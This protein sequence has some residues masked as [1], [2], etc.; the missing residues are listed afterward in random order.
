MPIVM[1]SH[2]NLLVINLE[3]ELG[4]AE[5][6]PN[7]LYVLAK[8]AFDFGFEDPI[9]FVLPTLHES[10]GLVLPEAMACRDRG[11]YG[12]TQKFRAP[13]FHTVAVNVRRS[14]TLQ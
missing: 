9:L 1:F 14:T 12:C 3:V 10:F 13:T 2:R 4:G 6:M 5:T 11:N 7:V 8:H